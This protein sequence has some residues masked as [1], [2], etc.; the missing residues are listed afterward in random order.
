MFSYERGTPVIVPRSWAPESAGVAVIWRAIQ[1]HL[2][3]NKLP[4][5]LGPPQ[6]PRLRRGV[7]IMSEVPL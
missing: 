4:S 1:S 3:H 7:F 6:D 2:A 5:P